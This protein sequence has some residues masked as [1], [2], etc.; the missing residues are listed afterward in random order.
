MIF[1]I[2]TVEAWERAKA[3]G[4]YAADSLDREGFI[5]CSDEHQV[6]EVA[7]RLFAG[8]PGLVLLQIDPSR[9]TAKVQ[10]ENLEGGKEQ[11]PHVYGPIPLTAIVGA[12]PFTTE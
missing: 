10:Y 12:Q 4:T 5:H 3:A 2:T 8:R 7:K 9:L 1:H 11:Y 6:A